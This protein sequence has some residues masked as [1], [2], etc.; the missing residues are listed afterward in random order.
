[1]AWVAVKNRDRSLVCWEEVGNWLPDANFF[2]HFLFQKGSDG[3]GDDV[4]GQVRVLEDFINGKGHA[5]GLNLAEK[6]LFLCLFPKKGVLKS[7]S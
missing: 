5:I 3:L 1:M 2:G 4:Y 7:G 6:S